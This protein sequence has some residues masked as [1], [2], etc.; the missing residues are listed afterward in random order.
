MSIIASGTSITFPNGSLD[1]S[2]NNGSGNFNNTDPKFVN[3]NSTSSNNYGTQDF[4]LLPASTAKGA[5]T[6]LTDLGIYGGLY[7]WVSNIGV[8]NIPQITQFNIANPNVATNGTLKVTV[9]AI[10]QK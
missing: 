6:D 3:V 1:I 2:N 4:H 9:K 10:K 8:S 7:P 5:A